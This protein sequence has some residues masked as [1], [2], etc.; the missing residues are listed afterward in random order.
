MGKNIG[1]D[2][3]SNRWCDPKFVP[4]L[5]QRWVTKKFSRVES[6]RTQTKWLDWWL[7]RSNS[8]G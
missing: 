5:R 6:N 8:N 4:L 1:M 7:F 3:K 2:P